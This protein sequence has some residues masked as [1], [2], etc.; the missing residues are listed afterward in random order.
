V[1][2]GKG[3][4]LRKE[5]RTRTIISIGFGVIIAALIVNTYFSYRAVRTLIVNHQRGKVSTD[6]L[7]ELEL[8]LSFIKDAE[9]GSRGYVITGEESYLEPYNMARQQFTL[10]LDNLKR[11]ATDRPLL[12]SKIPDLE[13]LI[14]ERNRILGEVNLQRTLSGFE[15]A[16]ETILRGE[17][18][19]K[20]D[21]LRVYVEDLAALEVTHLEGLEREIEDSRHNVNLTFAIV[22]LVAFILMISVYAL[23]NLDISRRQRTA[24]ALREANDLLED[25]VEHRTRQLQSVN[26]SL[27]DEVDERKRTEEKLEQFTRELERSNREL[28]DFAFVASHDLQEPLRKIQAFGDR[29]KSKY[30]AS[31]NEDGNDYLERMGSAARRMHTLINDL[32]TYSRVTTKA[33]P[34]VEVNLDEI[35]REV[36]TDLEIRVQQ[37]GGRVALEGLPSIEADAL[38]MRQLLQ[39]LIG[40]ALK[41]HRPDVAPQVTIRSRILNR[42]E[43]G[44]VES[45]AEEVCELKIEDQGIGFDEKYLDRI[46][47][48]FQRLHARTDYEGTGMGLAVCR[49]IV[50]RHG[51]TITAQSVVGQGT[52][53]VVMLPTT[54]N[55]GATEND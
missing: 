4:A 6:L 52:T 28:Q 49:K 45:K 46:F 8:T 21:E 9:T 2:S 29:L 53:F 38:Q 14:M 23:L 5:M 16:R 40:N 17:G 19:E 42:E 12:T 11:L 15:K 20:M 22:S 50:E 48:P 26:E 47:T 13:K 3:A 36:L 24:E 54:Q 31:L 25:R 33:Q 43:A 1:I 51:G 30:G 37:T 44:L 34:F 39:N 27:L 10:H 7:R 41:F 35:A 55:E 32:L 18:K